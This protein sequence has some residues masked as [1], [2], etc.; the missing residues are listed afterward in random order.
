MLKVIIIS[1]AA[2]ALFG[3]ILRLFLRKVFKATNHGKKKNL[4]TSGRI[5]RLILGTILFILAY[6]MSWSAIVLFFAGFCFFEAW[7]SWCGLYAVIGK[8]SCPLEP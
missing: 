5:L 6:F 1:L 4:N 3:F 2:G 8:D 7:F